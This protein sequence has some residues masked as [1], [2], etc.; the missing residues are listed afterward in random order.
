MERRELL[1]W[2]AATA[3]LAAL[4]GLAPDDLLALGRDVHARRASSPALSPAASR[5]VAA[6]AERILPSGDTPGATDAGVPEFI[7]RMLADWFD[8]DERARFLAG[9]PE[10]D[11]SS[12][13]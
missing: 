6:A 3:G 12:R 1:R 13:A 5:A 8:S 9:I 7:D 2:L 11:R 4:E 10:L